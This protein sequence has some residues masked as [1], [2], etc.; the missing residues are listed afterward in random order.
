MSWRAARTAP[1]SFAC[2]FVPVVGSTP[3][4]CSSEGV[5]AICVPSGVC[6]WS[7]EV[8]KDGFT[9]WGAFGFACGGAKGLPSGP[10]LLGAASLTSV[11][12]LLV[13]STASGPVSNSLCP[14]A[15]RQLDK[16]GLS[17]SGLLL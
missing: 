9:A 8:E 4:A 3:A 17:K 12:L 10:T 7:R 2:S 14:V 11:L 5:P 16:A 15:H 1:D 6:A 13:N